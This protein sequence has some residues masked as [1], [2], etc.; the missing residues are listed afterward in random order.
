MLFLYGVAIVSYL[1]LN[2]DMELSMDYKTDYDLDKLIS[3]FPEDWSK[4]MPWKERK[5]LREKLLWDPTLN[6]WVEVPKS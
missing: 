2:V 4:K 6:R 3:T 5:T 1:T